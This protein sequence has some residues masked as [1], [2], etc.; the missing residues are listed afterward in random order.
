MYLKC[1]G[2][3]TLTLQEIKDFYEKRIQ[4]PGKSIL[5][6]IDAAFQSVYPHAYFNQLKVTLDLSVAKEFLDQL[7]QRCI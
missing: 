4:L 7:T 1:E 3:Y 6:T 2:Y 5:L